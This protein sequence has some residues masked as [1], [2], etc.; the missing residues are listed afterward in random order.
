ML[1]CGLQKLSLLDYPEKLAATVFT[2]GCNFRCPFCHNALLVTHVSENPTISQDEFFAFLETRQG[3]LDGVCI[4]G[5]E[6]L[7][8]TDIAD[9]IRKIRALGFSVKLDTNG[10]FP[11]RLA[12]LLDEGLLD[13]VAM[14]FKNSPEKYPLTVGISDFD[15]SPVLE[16][17]ALLMNSSVSHEFRTTLVKG[18]HTA[19]DVHAMGR[20]LKGAKNYYL[21]SFVDSG[22]LIGFPADRPQLDMSGFLKDEMAEFLRILSQYVENADLRG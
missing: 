9:F 12:S 8:Q 15:I 18:L 13:Y 2:G 10:A 6:P 20:A 19:E 11:E 5:G 1:I 17:A 7:L 22:C 14:D 16:S 21:Q 3:K 4:T